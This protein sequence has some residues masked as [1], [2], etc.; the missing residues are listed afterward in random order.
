M[1]QHDTL[2]LNGISQPVLRIALGTWA[3]GGWQWG[4]PDDKSAVSTIHQ[5]LDEGINLID[6]APVYGFG[7]S[8]EIVGEALQGRRDKV[9]IATKVGLNWEGSEDDRHIF[10]DSRSDR[11]RKELEDSLR[12]LKTDYIDLYQI[13]WPDPKVPMEE[14]A[15]TLEKMRKEGKIRA[16]GVS[17]FT[18]EQMDEFRKYALLTSVQPPY[19]MFE[20][21]IE[22]DI[23][24]Y[25]KKHNLTVLTYGSLCRGLLSGKIDKNRVFQ[26][27]DLRKHDPK[28]MEP[29][30]DQYLAAV[31]ELEEFA[32]ESHKKSLLALAVRWV[33]DQGKHNIALW[34]ARK[35][36][37]VKNVGEALGWSL[38]TDDMREINA[39]LAKNI[40][41]AAGP[42]FSSPPTR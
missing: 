17:N 10:R 23:L 20:R 34:G 6:T 4:G 42:A 2:S 30:F 31:K 21:D 37:Q 3:M 1:H 39:I 15:I 7:H 12:R 22:K 32:Q 8:E 18:L 41:H 40:K 33:L 36:E 11:I 27:D 25:A 14:V 28:F 29:L 19:N 35:P 38:S 16:I 13:H 9:V 26:G 24:P 5:A